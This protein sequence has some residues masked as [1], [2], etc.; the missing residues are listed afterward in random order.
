MCTQ[1][2]KDP[3]TGEPMRKPMTVLT[4]HPG[5]YEQL[6][7]RKCTNH[8]NH[9]PIEGSTVFEGHSILRAQFSEVYP[10]K[11]SRLIAKVMSQSPFQRP[12]RWAAGAWCHVAET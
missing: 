7:G 6:H 3:A 4:T 11:F 12:F 9:Q 1:G 2:L 10:R 8:P 5:I